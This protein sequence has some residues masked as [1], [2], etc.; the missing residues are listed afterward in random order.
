MGMMDGRSRYAR[1]QWRDDDM[2]VAVENAATLF[3]ASPLSLHSW[4][5]HAA[6]LPLTALPPRLFFPVAAD[7]LPTF[8]II[9]AVI[10]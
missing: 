10:L 8:I 1:K 4:A 2:P 7:H 9:P 3:H 5:A 6:W